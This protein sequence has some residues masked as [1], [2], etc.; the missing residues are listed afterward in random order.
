MNRLERVT[1]DDAGILQDM[2][3]P[4]D[5]RHVRN[6]YMLNAQNDRRPDTP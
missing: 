4:D 2:D 6:L 5:Y 1:V 3:T